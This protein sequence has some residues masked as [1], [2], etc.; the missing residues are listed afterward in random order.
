MYIVKRESISSRSS[1]LRISLSQLARSKTGIIS[2][3][4]VVL[5][6]TWNFLVV[7][8]YELPP[9]WFSTFPELNDRNLYYSQYLTKFSTHLSAFL[10]GIM[11]GYLARSISRL[12][13]L[14]EDRF[15]ARQASQNQR[16]SPS[17]SSS[18]K[19]PSQLTS[20]STL[21][22]SASIIASNRM[23]SSDSGSSSRSINVSQDFTCKPRIYN[24]IYMTI[25][26]LVAMFAIIFSTFSW[27]TSQLPSNII[28]AL[29]DSGSRLVWSL[30]LVTFMLRLVL[31]SNCL[32]SRL[33]G[34]P[35]SVIIGRLS[36]LAYLVSPYIHNFMLA[37]QE[38]P[39][40]P[41]LFIIFH[42]IVGN[43]LLTYLMALLIAVIIEQPVKRLFGHLI[44]IK[45]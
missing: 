6:V 13:D 30:A 43:M 33:L 44:I 2:L 15:Q 7:L 23:N 31:N 45:S 32:A 5:G 40:F 1:L 42:I 17:L 41:S 10:V 11:G 39:L 9:A 27:S 16:P 28:S 21:S 35:S 20:N 14:D 18:S 3:L 37:V 38:Q 24:S 8:T 22:S 26:P 25:A 29:Y 12:S 34:H 4:A 36:F 19:T